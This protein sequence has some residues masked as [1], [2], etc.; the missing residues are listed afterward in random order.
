MEWK[1]VDK[2]SCQKSNHDKRTKYRDFKVG[3]EVL[4]KMHKRYA[5]KVSNI[6]DKTGPYLLEWFWQM[7]KWFVAVLIS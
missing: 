5:W 1:V 3:D 6:E 7:D 4:V 2:Q